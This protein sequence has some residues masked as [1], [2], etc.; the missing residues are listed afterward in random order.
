LRY[1]RLCSSAS[2]LK[3]LPRKAGGCS[4]KQDVSAARIGDARQAH[5]RGLTD[6]DPVDLSV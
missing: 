5:D 1:S 6:D 4:I 2:D 3:Q